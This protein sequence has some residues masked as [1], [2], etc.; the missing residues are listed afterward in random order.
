MD[1]KI[2]VTYVSPQ[3]RKPQQAEKATSSPGHRALDLRASRATSKARGSSTIACQSGERGA[4]DDCALRERGT[5]AFARYLGAKIAHLEAQQRGRERGSRR[6]SCATSESV[7][8]VLQ[9]FSI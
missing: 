2:T 9:D 5:A 1:G 6:V 7:V 8:A 3:A 4:G